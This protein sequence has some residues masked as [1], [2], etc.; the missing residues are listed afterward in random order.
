MAGG[1]PEKLAGVPV[2]IGGRA[3]GPDGR[4]IAFHWCVTQRVRSYS[5]R[6]LGV[7]DLAPNAQPR[8]LTASYDFD[9]GS[10]VFGDNAA[11]RGGNGAILHWSP[12]GLC[13]FEKLAKQ[14]RTPR[15]REDAQ[16]GAVTEITLGDQP[17]RGVSLMPEA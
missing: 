12:E 17:V 1:L 7:M 9:M 4:R 6:D 13:V 3:L 2:G 8:N 15:L 11:P 16:T 5:Q 14:G 10:S